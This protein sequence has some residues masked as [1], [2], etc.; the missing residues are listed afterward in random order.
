MKNLTGPSVYV[1]AV[2][3]LPALAAA[4]AGSSACFE[5][6]EQSYEWDDGGFHWSA[7]P[8]RC[9]DSPQPASAAERKWGGSVHIRASG[10]EAVV[11]E[12]SYAWA[13]K[14]NSESAGCPHFFKTVTRRTRVAKGGV[15]YETRQIDD[16]QPQKSQ[17]PFGPNELI[18]ISNVHT[19]PRPGDPFVQVLS[20]DTIAGQPC[21]RVASKQSIP[22]AGGYEMCIFVTPANCPLA[23]YLQ[24]LELSTKGPDGKVI[25]HGRTTSLRY[26]GR[27]QVVPPGSIRAP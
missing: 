7:M 21:Q 20:N 15:L 16:Q 26:G 3:L 19:V 6:I 12:E 23:R 14:R 10:Q 27:G 11:I 8:D 25:W 18:Y 9:P 5:D 17:R 4:A 22:G 1:L 24:P 2:C 13:P